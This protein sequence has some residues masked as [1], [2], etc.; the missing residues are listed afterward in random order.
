MAGG[1]VGVVHLFAFR[2]FCVRISCSPVWLQTCYAA[3]DVLE[4]LLLL[5]GLNADITGLSY[6]TQLRAGV[7]KNKLIKI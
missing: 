5:Y 1:E 6:H 4:P 7:F 3:E 2:F